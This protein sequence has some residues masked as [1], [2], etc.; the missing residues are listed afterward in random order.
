LEESAFFTVPIARCFRVPVIVD[1][2]SDLSQQLRD[3]SSRLGQWLAKPAEI[4]RRH[5]L[6][7]AHYAVTV[8]PHLTALVQRESPGTKVMEIRDIPIDAA[9]REPAKAGTDRLRQELGLS[10]SAPVLV[11][12]GNFGS[13]QGLQLLIEAMPAVRTKHPSCKLLLVGGESLE[14]EELRRQAEKLSVAEAIVF[15]GRRP[16]E[17]MPE[18]MGLASVLLSPRVE[19]N[20]TPLKIYSYMA[21]GRPIV[22]TDLPTHN[23]VVEK[24]CAVLVPPTAEGLARGISIVLSAPELGVRLGA[25][26]RDRVLEHYSFDIFKKKMLEVYATLGHG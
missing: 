18:V 7:G 10:S 13:R 19:P 3:Q 15:A 2:D 11:Y 26:A 9:L 4:L 12:T 5:A 21:S 14:I 16:P 6:R 8:A 17:L 25:R 23:T 24:D 22:A 20:V 1:L